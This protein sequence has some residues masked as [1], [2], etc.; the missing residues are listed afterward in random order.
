MLPFRR[1]AFP[2]PWKL[3]ASLTHCP[4][5]SM[6]MPAQESLRHQLRPPELEEEKLMLF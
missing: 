4:E 1:S 6:K 5:P 3:C 2:F